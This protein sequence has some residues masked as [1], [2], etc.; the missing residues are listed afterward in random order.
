M[1]FFIEETIKI[2]KKYLQNLSFSGLLHLSFQS[3]DSKKT[4]YTYMHSTRK[5]LCFFESVLNYTFLL[6]QF[7]FY[8]IFSISEIN[9]RIGKNENH[10]YYYY[11][12]LLLDYN[13]FSYDL[14]KQKILLTDY[15]LH[16]QLTDHIQG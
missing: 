4:I 6:S 3:D 1:L 13:E 8:F 11:F 14:T 5:L 16:K 2:I 9:R 7:T 15:L 10:Y 12:S